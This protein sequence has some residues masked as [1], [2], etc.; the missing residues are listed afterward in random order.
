MQGCLEFLWSD[1]AAARALR[2]ALV[3]KVIPMLCPDGVVNGSY[4]CGLAGHDLNRQWVKPGPAGASAASTLHPTIFHARALMQEL[5]AGGRLSLYV[6]MHGHSRRESA[7]FYGCEPSAATSLALPRLP[8]SLRG[9][10]VAC[11][12]DDPPSHGKGQSAG[13]S[14][15][16]ERERGRLRV[17]MLPYLLGQREPLFSYNVRPLAG[18]PAVRSVKG[19]RQE[20]C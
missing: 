18:P 19:P 17:R 6:D 12:G 3:F 20:H 8:P 10:D 13:G 16:A 4:R 7:F 1:A 9:A 11:D 14:D 2:K 15:D 5:A